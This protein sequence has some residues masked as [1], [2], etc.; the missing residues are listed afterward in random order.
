MR[1]EIGPSPVILERTSGTHKNTIQRNVVEPTHLHVL[2]SVSI[3]FKTIISQIKML[4]HRK[5]FFITFCALERS[6]KEWS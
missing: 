3:F 6:G 1:D 5:V 4:C 2:C